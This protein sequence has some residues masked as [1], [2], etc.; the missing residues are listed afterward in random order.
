MAHECAGNHVA[1]RGLRSCGT[2]RTSPGCASAPPGRVLL[3]QGA[4][5]SALLARDECVVA[6][7]GQTGRWPGLGWP[8]E[9]G[10]SLSDVPPGSILPAQA[11]LRAG[12]SQPC[13]KGKNSPWFPP[14]AAPLGREGGSLAPRQ[15][16]RA[17][18]L[19]AGRPRLLPA[20]VLG[21]CRAAGGRR[22]EWCAALERA[23]P[24]DGGC[25]CACGRDSLLPARVRRSLPGS[26]SAWRAG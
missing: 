3:L 21:R 15:Y 5:A 23:A 9:S 13:H 8:G 16:G 22:P 6:A 14:V 11:P 24:F 1:P 12:L 10:P 17:L 4:R 25:D 18:P 26:P 7:L 2:Q 19:L 20:A